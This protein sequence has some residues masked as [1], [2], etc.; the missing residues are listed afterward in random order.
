LPDRNIRAYWLCR[1]RRNSRGR[2]RDVES[3]SVA[4]RAACTI[5]NDN[6]E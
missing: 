6:R 1:D 4:G 2:S 3:G 5:G